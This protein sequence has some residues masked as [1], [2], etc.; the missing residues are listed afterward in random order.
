[1]KMLL[2]ISMEN[3]L[4]YA[5]VAGTAW[6]L[7]YVIFKKRWWARKIIQRDASAH[8][9]RRELMWSIITALI[10][11]VVGVVTIMVGKAYGWQIYRKI[12]AY[13][14]PWFFVSIGIAIIVHDTWFYWTHRLIHHPSL[15]KL[16]HRVHHESNNPTPWA[17]YAFSP[18]EAVVQA[19]IFPLLAFTVPMH[20]LAFFC[21]MVW[22]ITFN[23]LG[24]TGY[25]YFPRWLMRSWIGK[26]VNTPT[27]HVQHHERLRGNYGLYFNVWDR[28]MGTNHPDYETRFEE[29]TTRKG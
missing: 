15:F 19:C 8:D 16:V 27:N 24:H 1:M 5:V 6:L 21:F 17:A 23:V 18:L 11:G 22:Q 3:W 2:G 28:L 4:R 26:I 7:A 29:V 14:W 12:E 9:V 20:P 25:E 13:G 10:Y